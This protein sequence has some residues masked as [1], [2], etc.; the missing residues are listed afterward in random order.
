MF[1]VAVSDPDVLVVQLFEFLQHVVGVS[2]VPGGNLLG[3]VVEPPVVDLL[4]VRPPL[5]PGLDGLESPVA[6]EGV[7]QHVELVAAHVHLVHLQA[8]L[9]AKKIKQIAFSVK[10]LKSR[11]IFPQNTFFPLII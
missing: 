7:V 9:K 4:L 10:K 1:P 8:F 2:A 11:P 5:G 3:K 6:G